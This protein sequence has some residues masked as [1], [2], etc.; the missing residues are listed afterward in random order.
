MQLFWFVVVKKKKKKCSR[1][2]IFPHSTKL[3]KVPFAPRLTDRRKQQHPAEQSWQRTTCQ[4]NTSSSLS[5]INAPTNESRLIRLP[6]LLRA[7]QSVVRYFIYPFTFLN[8]HTDTSQAN[9]GQPHSL[10]TVV[11]VLIVMFYSHCTKIHDKIMPVRSGVM[12][13]QIQ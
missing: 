3:V 9:R 7:C 11:I 1:S 13:S 8:T 2:Q 12:I 4:A 10:P 5:I 6:R